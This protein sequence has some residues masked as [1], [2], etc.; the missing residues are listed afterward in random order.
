MT[1]TDSQLAAII[2]LSALREL[3]NLDA[4]QEMSLVDMF[5]PGQNPAAYGLDRDYPEL[6]KQ[7]REDT[8]SEAAKA[9]HELW[10]T[11]RAAAEQKYDH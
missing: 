8:Q 4:L 10:W 11:R 6:R 7:A 3:L 1:I 5:P 9:M 2:D